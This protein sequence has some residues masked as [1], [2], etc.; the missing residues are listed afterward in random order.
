M[1]ACFMLAAQLI[2]TAQHVTRAECTIH[3]T[4]TDFTLRL[5]GHAVSSQLH[6]VYVLLINSLQLYI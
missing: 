1:Q 3:F 2:S 6:A 5:V 4:V